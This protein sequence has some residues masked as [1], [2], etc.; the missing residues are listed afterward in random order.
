MDIALVLTG[1]FPNVW[2]I[3]LSDV[4]EGFDAV[5]RDVLGDNALNTAIYIS[6]FTDAR[7]E[8]GD[9]GDRRGWWGDEFG[10]FGSKLWTLLR[11][12]ATDEVV[13]LAKVYAQQAL[14]WLTDDGIA[15]TVEVQTERTGLYSISISVTVS[16][17][18]DRAEN[19]RFAMNWQAVGA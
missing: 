12:K 5:A 7:A 14:K 1:A 16:K 19:F 10:A 15:Q 18:N 11:E 4:P 17:P 3:Q 2:D 6:L 13:D 9:L 8:G